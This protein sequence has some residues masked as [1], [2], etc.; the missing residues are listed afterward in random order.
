MD[1]VTEQ[2]TKTLNESFEKLVTN[3][4]EKYKDFL[5]GLL[6]G[7]IV[8]Y[9]YNKLVGN[10]ALKDS[11]EKTIKTKDDFITVCKVLVSERLKDVQVE[12]KDKQFFNRLKR[13]FK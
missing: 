4:V 3:G 10:K 8:A 11:Y 1:K 9:F 6:I 7:L 12:Q 13:F 2:A 5:F